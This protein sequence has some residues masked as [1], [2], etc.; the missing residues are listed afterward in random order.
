MLVFLSKLPKAVPALLVLALVAAGLYA[1][2][3]VGS[4]VLLFV[5]AVL[6]WLAYLSWPRIPAPGRLVRLAVVALV[7]AY[8]LSRLG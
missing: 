8:A 1:P 5:A 4:V 6:G 2:P 7:V 3:A